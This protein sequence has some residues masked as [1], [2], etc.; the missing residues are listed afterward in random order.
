MLCMYISPK[1]LSEENWMAVD[2]ARA[3]NETKRIQ[4]ER[5]YPKKSLSGGDLFLTK[6]KKK[7]VPLLK[8]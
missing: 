2:S 1:I 6:E 4:K 8:S 7:T 3:E 5:N